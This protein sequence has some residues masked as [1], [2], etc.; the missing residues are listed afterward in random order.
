M[1]KEKKTS[2][3]QAI[4]DLLSSGVPENISLGKLKEYL[5]E[6][7]KNLDKAEEK[8]KS[9]IYPQHKLNWNKNYINNFEIMKEID[10]YSISIFTIISKLI[11][12]NNLIQLSLIDIINITNYSK[13]KIIKSIN[14]LIEKGFIAIKLKGE[15]K[16]SRSTI[17]MLNPELVTI[18]TGKQEKLKK[19]FWQLTGSKYKL[20]ILNEPSKIHIDWL[21]I[22][23][24]KNYIIGYDKI[25]I[26]DKIIH[27]NKLSVKEKQNKKMSAQNST[28]KFPKDN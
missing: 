10:T 25:Q 20:N 15:P 28:D 22:I 21:N 13:P 3:E 8:F 7:K 4:D 12:K 24:N 16:N 19:E 5:R 26:D 1:K 9:H 27:F 17:Y 18:G 6:N 11:N 2:I 23:E 14:E